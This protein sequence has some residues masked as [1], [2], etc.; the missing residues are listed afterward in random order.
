MLACQARSLSLYYLYMNTN[1]I[2]PREFIGNKVAGIMFEN[3][4][5]HTT[6]FGNNVEYIQGIHMMPLLPHTIMIRS[7]TF[8]AQE[9]NAYFSNGRA[10]KVAGGWKGILF[11]NLATID[12]KGAY[13]FF[14]SP[15]FDHGWLDG[16][17]S[18]TWYLAYAAGEF[19]L[20]VPGLGVHF[21]SLVIKLTLVKLWVGCKGEDA[22]R[23][24]WTWMHSGVWVVIWCN[25]TGY[26]NRPGD[27]LIS[28]GHWD[29]IGSSCV[30][31]GLD[32]RIPLENYR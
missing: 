13:A 15:T 2:E 7:P 6:Y 9:W 5:D 14:S 16:G 12:P 24:L 27:F 10:E 3:K 29:K 26:P 20:P 1:A 11:G 30:A 17:A 21:R 32:V 28:F 4:I 19:D 23:M 25:K 18:L 31:G 8:V 22:R